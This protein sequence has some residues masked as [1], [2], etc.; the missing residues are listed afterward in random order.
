MVQ[1][2]EIANFCNSKR[3]IEMLSFISKSFKD[4]KV[5]PQ[6]EECL[7]ITGIKIRIIVKR[8]VDCQTTVHEIHG[9]VLIYSHDHARFTLL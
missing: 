6:K 3:N 1:N 5:F 9:N 4:C 2:I 7:T 8:P